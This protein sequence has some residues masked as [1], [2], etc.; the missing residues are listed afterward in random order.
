MPLDSDQESAIALAAQVKRQLVDFALTPPFERH[1]RRIA[2]R[3][4]EQHPDGPDLGR[5]D[6]PTEREPTPTSPG[7]THLSPDH[8]AAAPLR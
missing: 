1:L 5:I 8:C 6:D 3:L 7:R 2:R 4:A